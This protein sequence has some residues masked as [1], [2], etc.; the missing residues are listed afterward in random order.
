[1]ALTISS[2]SPS[3]LAHEQSLQNFG[4]CVS[5]TRV[6]HGHSDRVSF[7]D[8][9]KMTPG[10]VRR[11]EKG[12]LEGVPIE[13]VAKVVGAFKLDRQSREHLL[14]LATDALVRAG[15]HPGK[16]RQTLSGCWA[17]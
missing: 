3:E 4:A 1:M 6:M 16:V 13:D 2:K 14:A 8:E 11:I 17:E 9:L 15:N 10:A 12:E 5:R 7:A